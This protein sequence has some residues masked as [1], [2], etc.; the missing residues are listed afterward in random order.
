M[1]LDESMQRRFTLTTLR[2]TTFPQGLAATG[3]ERLD[4]RRLWYN[5]IT[6]YEILFG[7]TYLQLIDF[8]QL[9]PMLNITKNGRIRLQVGHAWQQV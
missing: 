3:L 5:L 6:A 4:V 9:R 1:E 8:F 7:S 2:N